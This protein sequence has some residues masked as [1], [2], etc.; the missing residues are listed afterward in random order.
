VV[1]NSYACIPALFDRRLKLTKGIGGEYFISTSLFQNRKG[2]VFCPGDRAQA[3]GAK[4]ARIDF[5]TCVYTYLEGFMCKNKFLYLGMG[6]IILLCAACEN[7]SGKLYSGVYELAGLDTGLLKLEPRDET[8]GNFQYFIMYSGK[9]ASSGTGEETNRKGSGVYTINGNKVIL[10]GK[11]YRISDGRTFLNDD[12]T[13]I[14]MPE[15]PLNVEEL[16]AD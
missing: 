13:W 3:P 14:W 4:D 15:Q 12:E 9:V 10:A 2:P 5:G 11:E 7:S 16:F 8:S 6:L 1:K